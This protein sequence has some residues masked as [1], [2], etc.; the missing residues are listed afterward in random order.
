MIKS[1]EGSRK[2]PTESES[3]EE[4]HPEGSASPRREKQARK[5]TWGKEQ[6]AR[7]AIEL[8]RMRRQARY[9]PD[10]RLIKPKLRKRRST[11][12]SVLSHTKQHIPG[13]G[14]LLWESSKK[15]IQA[16][17]FEGETIEERA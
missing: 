5:E 1:E 17:E 15:G 3:L 6:K 2:P 9:A 13:W 14:P 16:L 10:L 4:G 8:S 12:L 7:V 11:C